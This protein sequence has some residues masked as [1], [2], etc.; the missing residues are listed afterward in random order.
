MLTEFGIEHTVDGVT[1]VTSRK[2]AGCRYVNSR[3]ETSGKILTIPEAKIKVDTTYTNYS[4]NNWY[5][6]SCIIK[7]L[8]TKGIA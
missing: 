2:S 1:A 4:T 6:A 5:D 3:T 8:A 7:L